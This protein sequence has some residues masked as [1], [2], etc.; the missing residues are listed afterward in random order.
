MHIPAPHGRRAETR[1]VR[2]AALALL[3]AAPLAA[4][5]SEEDEADNAA[6]AIQAPPDNAFTKASPTPVAPPSPE[7]PAF[8]TPEPAPGEGTAPSEAANISTPTPE[9]DA[10]RPK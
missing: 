9:S 4:C 6:N 5:G 7:D 8:V 1:P 2:L 3:L 10:L